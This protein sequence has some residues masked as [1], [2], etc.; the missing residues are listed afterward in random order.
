MPS[1]AIVRTSNASWKPSYPPVGVFV[2]GPS[3]IGEG[4]VEAFARHTKGNAHILIKAPTP[5][6]TR[7]FFECDLSLIANAKRTAAAI[8]AR[9]PRVSFV[10]M[11]AGYVSSNPLDITSEG[12]DS[13]VAAMYYSKWALMHGLL[14]ALRAAKAAGEDARVAVHTAGRGVPIDLDNLGL[15]KCLDSGMSGMRAMIAQIASYQD[16]MAEVRTTLAPRRI[17]PPLNEIGGVQSFAERNPEISFT[18]R[19]PGLVDTP[20]LHKSP[21]TMFRAIAKLVTQ[22]G[23]C[24]LYALLQAKPGASRTGENGDDVRLGGKDDAHWEEGKQALWAHTEKIVSE[25]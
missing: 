15:G 14:P 24:Q 2:G 16:L 20:L 8:V 22:C 1:L 12:V 10:F 13:R 5:E 9:F 23:E 11:T 19:F 21:S 25:I 17:A 6:L 3:G 4:I 7:E 18:H